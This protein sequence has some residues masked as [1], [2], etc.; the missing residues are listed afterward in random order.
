MGCAQS[1]IENEEAVVRCKE[2]R[3]WMKSA[4]S[5][6]NAFSAAHSAYA[7]GLKNT[8]AALAEFGQGESYDP[9]LNS[10]YSSS[11]GV[12][13]SSSVAPI[14]PPS[15]AELLPP[16]R[17]SEFSAASLQ[18]SISMPDLPNKFPSKIK[19]ESTIRE[20]DDEGEEEAEADDE[21]ED[22]EEEER[23]TRL[24]RRHRTTRADAPYENI[25]T[26]VPRP[27]TVDHHDDEPVTPEKVVIEPPLPPNVP[28]KLKQG[29]NVHHQQAQ[30]VSTLD[31]KRGKI[32]PGTRPSVNL[33]KILMDLDDHFLKASESTNDVL[34][35]LEATRMHYHS[36]F[37]DNRGHIDH[38][39][40]VMRVITWNRSFKG[41]SGTERN[42]D[43]FDDDDE[44]ETHATVL[45][46]IL[47]WEKKLYDEVKPTAHHSPL[48]KGL[49]IS[50]SLHIPTFFHCR[51]CFSLLPLRL[52]GIGGSAGVSM[53]ASS[54]ASLLLQKQLRDL[55]KNPVDGFS[56][57]L[58]DDSNV[59]EWNVTIIGPPDTLYDGGFFNAV[60]SF[61]PNYPNSPPTVRFTSEMWHPNVYPD[62]RVCI[63]I[64]HPPGEDPNGYELPSERWTPIHTDTCKGSLIV[65][66]K[67]YVVGIYDLHLRLSCPLIMHEAEHV[68]VVLTDNC[69]LPRHIEWLAVLLVVTEDE[70]H[71]LINEE[72]PWEHW[73]PYEAFLSK[74][75]CQCEPESVTGVAIAEVDHMHYPIKEIMPDNGLEQTVRSVVFGGGFS[76]TFVTKASS[77]TLSSYRKMLELL[78]LVRNRQIRQQGK[79]E[80][81]IGGSTAVNFS[82]RHL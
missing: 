42:K 47:A 2:R 24:K 56:A 20:D 70:L 55:M 39:A 28:K 54:P 18:R 46:K 35:M 75:L 63:S 32:V 68:V 36:N 45:D 19:P 34:K 58:V 82:T 62:G 77:T 73:L 26:P 31:S 66:L 14:Q 61:P 9:N 16:P 6:R 76:S 64:L 22:D 10:S 4:V 15:D 27:P 11:S 7:V 5:A 57:G 44:W 1:R 53:A 79:V 71:D 74:L 30:S 65:S 50:G 40:R 51:L 29:R 17:P 59:F 81:G 12:E 25:N 43:D 67:P 38:A 49:Y 21:E 37:A 60:M 13:P 41:V 72:E 48:V 78:L 8:G 33:A 52:N 80:E 3:Q 23:G 69:I